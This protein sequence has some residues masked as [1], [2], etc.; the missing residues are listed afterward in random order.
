MQILY[1]FINLYIWVFI[2]IY[3]EIILFLGY[4]DINKE[5]KWKTIVFEESS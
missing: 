1:H 5:E 4:Y 2:F 3:H